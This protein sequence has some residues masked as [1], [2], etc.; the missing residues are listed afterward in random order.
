MVTP[1]R[2]LAVPPAR[3]CPLS[4]PAGAMVAGPPA[5]PAEPMPRIAPFD[6]TAR[7]QAKIA[8][9]RA[10]IAKQRTDGYKDAADR[11][12]AQVDALEKAMLAADERE[13]IA[14]PG[15]RTEEL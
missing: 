15:R 5:T 6:R 13:P 14:P 11:L 4:Q 7:A 2:T 9:A 8:E 10:W 1:T 3:H 12:E